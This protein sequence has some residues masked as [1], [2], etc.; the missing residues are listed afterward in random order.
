MSRP[1]KKTHRRAQAS[2][3]KRL[4]RTSAQRKLS[5]QQ[6]AVIGGLLS[7]FFVVESV[8]YNRNNELKVI[9]TST[10]LTDFPVLGNQERE[11]QE[12]V[13]IDVIA[14]EPDT[15]TNGAALSHHVR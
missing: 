3:K 12:E 9:L 7:G 10:A 1:K 11:V 6:A 13:P 4:L 14:S 2:P 5:P 15:N 8:L